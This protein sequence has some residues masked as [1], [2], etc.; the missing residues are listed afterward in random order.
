MSNEDVQQ[1]MAITSC[2]EEAAKVCLQLT[3]NLNDAINFYFTEYHGLINNNNNS[4]NMNTNQPIIQEQTKNIP[5]TKELRKVIKTGNRTRLHELLTLLE[6]EKE[7]ISSTLL[8]TAI[9]HGNCEILQDLISKDLDLEIT[10]SI[11]NTPLL[12]SIHKRKSECTKLLA[13]AK[14]NPLAKT[15][16]GRNSLEYCYDISN[17]QSAENILKYCHLDLS[18]FVDLE[19]L[20]FKSLSDDKT[21]FIDLFTKYGAEPLKEKT[22]GVSL[23]MKINSPFIRTKLLKEPKDD[24]FQKKMLFRKKDHNSIINQIYNISKT[25]LSEIK[26]HQINN[27]FQYALSGQFNYEIKYLLEKGFPL[28]MIKNQSYN[29]LL[30]YCVYYSNL[31]LASLILTNSKIRPVKNRNQETPI[32]LAC[33]L[34]NTKMFLILVFYT[35]G[36]QDLSFLTNERYPPDIRYQRIGLEMIKNFDFTNNNQDLILNYLKTNTIALNW[37]DTRD[38]FYILNNIIAKTNFNKY[39]ALMKDQ[40]VNVIKF[41]DKLHIDQFNNILSEEK[42]ILLKTKNNPRFPKFYGYFFESHNDN[43]YFCIATE[44][45][46]KG[47]LRELIIDHGNKRQLFDPCVILYLAIEIANSLNEMHE[48]MGFKHPNFGADVIKIS[49]NGEIKTEIAKY[50]QNYPYYSTFNAHRN[51]NITKKTNLFSY[52]VIL[53]E[54]L[55]GNIY[56]FIPNNN[57][58]NMNN[59]HGMNM[60]GMNMNNMNMNGMNMGQGWSNNNRMFNQPQNT[61]N[62]PDAMIRTLSNDCLAKDITIIWQNKVINSLTRIAKT[63]LYISKSEIAVSISEILNDLYKI[64]INVPGGYEGVKNTYQRFVKSLPDKSTFT[65]QNNQNIM[66]RKN[67]ISITIKNGLSPFQMI[68]H[69]YYVQFNKKKIDLKKINFEIFQMILS[70]ESLINTNNK[71]EY[72]SLSQKLYLLLKKL[73]WDRKQSK[74]TKQNLN[75]KMICDILKDFLN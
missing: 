44:Y 37:I 74:F 26:T 10:N 19:K 43:H 22:D 33:R 36:I 8:F 20:L 57:M 12:D 24:P 21:H 63:L 40:L 45:F 61:I 62:D 55:M 15:H 73:S 50:E 41:N 49:D 54:L 4:I 67:K 32:E 34:G 59:M 13:Q 56:Q 69:N 52:G 64:N 38:H 53:Y 66:K 65:N 27:L 75:Q 35:K 16:T 71:L 60:N 48:Q 17:H 25:D 72:H 9:A 39:L 5:T 28:G 11:G 23:F 14:S 31:N 58:N 30:H 51:N 3:N 29:T 18:Q 70:L 46:I 7:E 47:N 68:I 2:T 42:S 6:K 1:L